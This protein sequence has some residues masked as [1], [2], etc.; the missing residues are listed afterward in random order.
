LQASS[1]AVTQT[2]RIQEQPARGEP[3][4][5]V[6]IVG[7]D[8]VSVAAFAT[9]WGA[10]AVRLVT[11]APAPVWGLAG[12]LAL[13]PGYALADA[14]SGLLHWF[15]DSFFEEDAPVLGRLLIAPFREHHRDAKG[16]THHGFL[17]V[18]GNNCA[19]CLALLVPLWLLLPAGALA[20][21]GAATALALLLVTTFFV[22]ATNGFHRWAHTDEVPAPIGWLQRRGWILSPEQHALHHSGDHDRAYCVTSG[23]LN[24]VF[25][26]TGV[27]RGISQ[28]AAGHSQ[29]RSTPP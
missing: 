8:F 11:E 16:I 14:A 15:A 21:L 20:P 5:P 1:K 13:L 4:R 9:V 23:W 17:E 7:F 25:D 27:L 29:K 18:C 6:W 10:L 19:A 22:F 24:A 26:G 2:R 12:V 28:R 3:G